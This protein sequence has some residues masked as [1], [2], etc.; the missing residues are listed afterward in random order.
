M[1]AKSLHAAVSQHGVAAYV[2][3]FDKALKC[4]RRE[5]EASVS[6][7]F[8]ARVY[9]R[10]AGK[11]DSFLGAAFCRLNI[12]NGETRISYVLV[13]EETGIIA[14]ARNDEIRLLVI[15]D[16]SLFDYK[17]QPWMLKNGKIVIPPGIMDTQT[18][19]DIFYRQGVRKPDGSPFEAKDV[20]IG[21]LSFSYDETGS[22]VPYYDVRNAFLNLRTNVKELGIGVAFFVE[23]V[24]DGIVQIVF[25][26]AFRGHHMRSAKWYPKELMTIVQYNDHDSF[27]SSDGE[28]TLLNGR[29]TPYQEWI[30]GW[31]LAE[32]EKIEQRRISAENR[33]VG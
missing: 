26:R 29:L 17:G 24:I 33:T 21:R 3:C 16:G 2:D 27:R 6:E 32:R 23:T 18:V 7:L 8:L 20:C 25:V 28:W 4:F 12:L 31:R 10:N 13:F 30:D 22:N 1:N 5:S 11:A 14:H 15:K 19:A 9:R